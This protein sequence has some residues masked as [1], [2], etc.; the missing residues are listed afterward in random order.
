MSKDI[1]WRLKE[2]KTLAM[3]KMEKNFI[4]LCEKKYP[5][6]PYQI[7]KPEFLVDRIDD[8]LRELKEALVIRDYQTVREECADIIN[9]VEY[10][11]ELMSNIWDV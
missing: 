7:Y 3:L 4:A 6:Q 2:I 1:K 11:F 9:I 8:E 5:R 10:L